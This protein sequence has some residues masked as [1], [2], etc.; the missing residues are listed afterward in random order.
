MTRVMVLGS[1][2]V[3]A[4]IAYELS[5][6]A[7]LEVIVLDPHF[8]GQGAT[9]AALGV[10]MAVI[11]Q[12]L[13]GKGLKLRLAS[14]KRYE[15]LIPELEAQIQCPIPY[16][17]AGILKLSQTPTELATWPTLIAARS[18]QGW[19]L[20]PLNAAQLQAS[21]P[22][23]NTDSFPHGLFSPG[24]RQVHPLI[25]TQALVTAAQ[26]NG[27]EFRS[28]EAAM[29]IP[30]QPLWGNGMEPAMG[31]APGLHH[32]QTLNTCT[33]VVTTRTT[34]SADWVVICAGIQS[35][36]LLRSLPQPPPPATAPLEI[37]P[38]LGQALR[39]RVPQ[40]FTMASEPVITAH[41]IHVVPLGNGQYW[42]GATVEFGEGLQPPQPDPAGLA[43]IWEQA[44]AFYPALSQG[45]ILETWSGLRPRPVGRPAPIVE[46]VAGYANLLLATGHYRNG[47]LL[48]PITAEMIKTIIRQRC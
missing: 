1:G 9:R 3:G 37:Q 41:D 10:L 12:K 13:K 35:S 18:Q 43:R 24:D 31:D 22:Q 26:Q 15:T 38:V 27:V 17:R 48:A 2:I 23:I 34:Y 19:P 32:P 30:A 45:E 39:L 44:T 21:Y 7:E 29:A 28:G 25:L 6:V 40:T 42:L 36:T 4:A 11:S 14:L 33:G 47:V 20:I 46:P 8:P 5:L 16:N